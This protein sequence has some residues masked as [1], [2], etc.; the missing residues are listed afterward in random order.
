M[1]WSPIGDPITTEILAKIPYKLMD[2]IEL[3]NALSCEDVFRLREK[4]QELGN[5]RPFLGRP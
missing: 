2:N 4:F 5:I 1:D 3:I